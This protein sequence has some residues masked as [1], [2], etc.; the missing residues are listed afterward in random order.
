MFLVT[1][2]NIKQIHPTPPLAMTKETDPLSIN[3]NGYLDEWLLPAP[4]DCRRW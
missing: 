4:G 3:W 2:N 1:Q